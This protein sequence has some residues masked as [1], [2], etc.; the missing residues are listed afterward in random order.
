MDSTTAH[1]LGMIFRSVGDAL[2]E[3]RNT[4]NLADP[5]NTNHGDH[6]VEIFRL[7]SQAADEKQ[8]SSL[9][10]AMEYAA[11]SME[12]KTKNGSA[13]T[14][15]HGLRQI[16]KQLRR[17]DVTLDELLTFVHNALIENKSDRKEEQMIKPRPGEVLKALLS[18]LAGWSEIEEG[19]TPSN[20][21]LDIGALFVFGMI[22]MQA[23]KKNTNRLDVLSDAAASAS[24]LVKIPHRY[25]S[26]RI[27]F[28]ALLQAMQDE[29][30]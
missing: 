23:K 22:Y 24:P 12:G 11:V 18:G 13:Q 20:N 28:R 5:F 10:E 17:S 27:A 25:Q 29:F 26:G 15:A 30:E 8:D 2:Q 4:L 19:K 3:N 6:M 1:S 16:G 9:A 21:P 7:A 14:Y